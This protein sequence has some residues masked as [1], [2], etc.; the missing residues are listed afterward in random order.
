MK[1]LT[2]VVEISDRLDRVLPAS[3][4]AL[5]RR[6]ARALI[7]AGAVYLDGK[8]C[9]VASR[10][11]PVGAKIVVHLEVPEP[12]EP[13][14]ILF[15]DED[16]VVVNKPAGLSANESETSPRASVVR[17]LGG[18]TKLVHRLD[19]DT[20]GVMVLARSDRAAAALSAAF[21][22]RQV[23]KRYVAITM[24]RPAEGWI[25][26]PIGADL[27]RPRARA[28]QPDGRPARTEVT[29]VGAK[30]GLA[31]V[32]LRLETG[33]MHQI[34]VHLSHIGTPILGDTQYGAKAAVLFEGSSHR[35][36]RPLLHAAELS[37]ELFGQA[38]HFEA[39]MP[40]DLATFWAPLTA[41]PPSP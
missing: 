35:I 18:E 4:P 2:F 21:R 16:I 39:P 14:Q 6:Q 9:K 1:T 11:T 33:R 24:G 25:D 22:E 7:T 29:V 40:A 3:E 34:R 17:S 27:R 8:R 12:A 37:F 30:E 5:S 31:A 19:L 13:A 26:A 32:S 15:E 20:T 36:L 28:V 10:Y 38:H 23:H 41:T